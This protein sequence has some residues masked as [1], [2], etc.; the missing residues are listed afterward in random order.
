MVKTEIMLISEL[1]PD[2]FERYEVWDNTSLEDAY[3]D[4]SFIM[5]VMGEQSSD[6][7]VEYR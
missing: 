5:E 1:N 6:I 7:K 2:I 3:K 4:F